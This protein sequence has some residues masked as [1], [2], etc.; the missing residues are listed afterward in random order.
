MSSELYE[1]IELST[2]EIALRRAN[3]DGKPLVVIKFSEESMHFLKEGKY[4]VAKAMIEAGMEA[5][6][7]LAAESVEAEAEAEVKFA[8]LAVSEQKTIH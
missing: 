6:S 2:G 5:A 7:E 8:D 4:E 1:I 3:E